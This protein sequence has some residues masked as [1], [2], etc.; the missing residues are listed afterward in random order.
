MN[1]PHNSWYFVTIILQN[2][3]CLSVIKDIVK[4]K[5]YNLQSLVPPEPQKS[6]KPT[7]SSE[8]TAAKTKVDVAGKTD[9]SQTTVSTAG[10]SDRK[11]TADKSDTGDQ[12]AEVS[13]AKTASDKTSIADEAV[14][15]DDK[16]A[17]SDTDVSG[18]S[19]KL[20]TELSSSP[21]ITAPA[22]GVGESTKTAGEQ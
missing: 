1:T 21:V 20:D 19:Q 11:D 2:L 17:G 3:C 5:K 13:V 12:I 6:S 16:T 22:T 18:Y 14:N 9:D 7:T 8:K 4:L 10:T 15:S